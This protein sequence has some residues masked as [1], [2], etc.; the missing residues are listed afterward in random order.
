MRTI[1]IIIAIAIIQ[2]N[3]FSQEQN[4]EKVNIYNPDANAKQDIVNAVS[5]AKKENKNV[6]IQVGGNW[7]SWC[8]RFHKMMHTDFKIDSMIKANYVYLMVN[9][10]KENKNLDVMKQLGNPQRFGF[11]VLVILDQ[12]GKQIHIQDSGF[13]ELD[14]G[15][16]PKKVMEFLNGWTVKAIS[17]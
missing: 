15:Y 16:D 10:S 12:Q 14:K 2:L 9:W 4:K 8:V 7:C 5:F 11:P 17:N 1:L 6:L 3:S 13:L